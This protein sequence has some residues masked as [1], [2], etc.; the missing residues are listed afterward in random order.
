MLIS[1][2]S[3]FIAGTAAFLGASSVAVAGVQQQLPVLPMPSAS[4]ALSALSNP[5][6][7]LLGVL[8]Q[9]QNYIFGTYF[10][11]G[12]APTPGAGEMNWPFAGLDQTGGD[13][14]NFLLANEASLGYYNSVGFLA[15]S[16]TDAGPVIQQLQ[17]NL[18]NYIN[19]GISGLLG[20][21][22]ALSAGVWDFPAAALDAL[23]LA[24]DGQISEA[25]TVLTDAVVVPITNAVEDIVGTGG[26]I[27]TD[28]VAKTVAV[29]SAIPLIAATAVSTAFGSV[30]LLAEKS[31]D[32][33]TTWITKLG[34]GDWEGAWNTA[35]DGLFGP[36]GLPGLV[37]NLTTGAGV[38]TGPIV[39]PETDIPANFV[40]SVRTAIQSGVWTVAEA[41]TATAP[42]AAASPAEAA[43]APKAAAALDVAEAPVVEAP[44]VETPAVEVPVVEA[45][46]V[47]APAAADVAA[48]AAGES[49]ARAVRGA[50]AR[51]G[52]AAAAGDSKSAGA[53]RTAKRAARAG[54]GV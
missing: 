53:N 40:P 51:A 52:E 37:L 4:V 50:T 54:A 14:L 29:I 47:E 49:P 28:F 2:R 41:L 20:S 48:P 45:P 25:F 26:Y 8:E 42:P 30:T 33:A 23:Q 1:L 34:S 46:A 21:I 15:Q 17:V 18:F 16:V 24:I 9:G 38:Q 39:D 5:I 27:L 31:I 13:T 12:E 43:P 22:A 7:Q 19:A 11:G 35:V 3:Q 36:S 32:I 6:E 10:D 44:V